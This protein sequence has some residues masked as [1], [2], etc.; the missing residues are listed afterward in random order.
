MVDDESKLAEE[1][2]LKAKIKLQSRS[3]FFS[4]LA[5]FLKIRKAKENE[6]PEY[7]GIGVDVRGIL[8]YNPK[9]INK[10]TDEEMIGVLCHEI[11]H[12]ALL[13]LTRRKNRENEKWNIC[14]D[15]AINSMLI[16]NGFSLAKGGLI[17]DYNDNFTFPEHIFGKKVRITECHKKTA[18]E[19]FEELPEI[20]KGYNRGQNEGDGWD[21]HSE[22]EGDDDGEGKGKDGKGGKGFGRKLTPA[23]IKELEEKWKDRIEEAL[24]NS[25]TRGNVPIGMERYFEELRKSQVNWRYILLRYVQELLPKDMTWAKKSKKSVA[26]HTYLPSYTKEK[27]DIIVN[28][29]LSG[30]IGQKELTDFVSEIV[31]MAKAFQTSINMRLLTHDTQIQSDLEVKNGN[32]EKIRKM[33]IKGGGGTEFNSSVEYINEKYPKSKCLIWLTD[34]YGTEIKEKT[35]YPIIWVICKGGSDEVIHNRDRRDKIIWLKD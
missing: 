34:G 3:P 18:E 32:V 8:Y 23:E 25:K 35:R 10:L 30:S 21:S 27:I 24:M 4:Y 1:K 20:K 13:H 26:C 22:G 7:A 19:M 15:L 29:D 14:T 31:G 11:G 6:L 33:E 12:L 5:L 16:K 9:W 28:I 2:L 17:P